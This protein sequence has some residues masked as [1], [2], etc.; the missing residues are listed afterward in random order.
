MSL[1][2]ATPN[3]AEKHDP[4]MPL[5]DLTARNLILQLMALVKRA[6]DA[7]ELIENVRAICWGEEILKR[8]PGEK[9]PRMRLRLSAHEMD[10]LKQSGVIEDDLC[11]TPELAKGVLPNGQAMTAL[12]KLLYSVLW[13]NGDLGKEHHLVAGVY[14]HAHQQKTGTVFHEFG[15]YLSGRNNFILDQHTLRCFAVACEQSDGVAQARRLASIDRTH[16]KHAEWIK[17]YVAFYGEIQKGKT[18]PVSDYLY[19]VDRL[20]FGAGKLIKKA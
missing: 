15:G 8:M 9:F 20:F 2:L 11:L 6:C 13:K 14:G 19:V 12:E 18:V 4:K 3:L 17:A 16:P 1:R 10:A 7:N 5:D